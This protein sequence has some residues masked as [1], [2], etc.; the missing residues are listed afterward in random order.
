MVVKSSDRGAYSWVPLPSGLSQNYW[1]SSSSYS[2]VVV[3]VL[4]NR[5][6]RLL[7]EVLVSIFVHLVRLEVL[8]LEVFHLLQEGLV[9]RHVLS[10]LG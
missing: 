8:L 7:W 5:L 1:T 2:L 9:R 3:K 10:P 6:C 4:L